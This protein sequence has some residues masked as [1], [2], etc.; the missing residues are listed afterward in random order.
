L[1]RQDLTLKP[2]PNEQEFID[3]KEDYKIFSG[4]GYVRAINID[5]TG[6]NIQ[7]FNRDLLP[8]GLIVVVIQLS[9]KLAISGKKQKA[10]HMVRF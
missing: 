6:A 5:N 10:D 7:V 2:F 9:G 4:K 1:S 3:Q 8:L